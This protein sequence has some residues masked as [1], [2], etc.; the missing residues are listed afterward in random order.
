MYDVI[1][2]GCGIV[3]AAA[4]LELSRYRLKVAVL[5]REND[6]AQGATKANS[7]LIHAGYDPEPGSLKAR[8]NVRGAQLAEQLCRALDV[9]YR[10]NGA[11]V[12]AFSSEEEETLRM[13]CERGKINGVPGLEL[14]SGEQARALEPQLSPEVTAVLRA[15]TA[16]ICLPWEYC[17]AMAETAVLNGVELFLSHEVKSMGRTPAGWHVVTDRGHFDT[18]YIINAAGVDAGEVQHMAA[19]A[20]WS[21]KPARGEYFLLDKSEGARTG[22][23]I[24]QCPTA[25]GKGVL[26]TPTVHGNLLVGPDSCPVEPH[27]NSNTAEGMAYVRA[28]SAKSVPSVDFRRSI[29]NYAGVRAN[30]DTGDFIIGEAE[31]APGFF[32][33]AGIG[34]PGLSAAPA[35]AEYL[36]QLMREAGLPTDPNPDFRCSRRKLRFRELS[37]EQRAEAVRKNP[38]YGRV[39]CRCETITEG[40]ILD[41]IRSPIPPCSVDGVKRR[42][43]AGLGRCQGGFCGPR[44]ADILRRELNL[45]PEDILQDRE[46]SY[47]LVGETKG[48]GADV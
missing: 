44:E 19:P 7:A 18:K 15:P 47:M 36:V 48:G 8:L 43:G 40:E 21:I 5:E 28:S 4:A 41:A 24:F 10:R 32:N 9:P 27:D 38:A 31:G 3:G 22:H 16:A 33:A 6:V 17:L 20:D 39:I 13:L 11:L 2:I 42:T 34:S 12:A 37:D 46:G 45:R 26:V 30:S 29:R 25:K 35:I 14:L 1:I 23:T